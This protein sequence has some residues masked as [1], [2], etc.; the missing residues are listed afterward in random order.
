MANLLIA[1]FTFIIFK[2]LIITK[3]FGGGDFSGSLAEPV[4]MFLT[5]SLFMNVSLAIFN[6]LPFPPLDGSKILET[7]LPSSLRP[8]LTVLERYGYLILMAL[9]YIG[10]FN[11]IMRPIAV[12]IGRLL[13]A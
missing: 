7:F 10:F 2:A 5:Y 12:F 11:T 4:G 9:I 6:L 1:I 3:P 13:S 8:A